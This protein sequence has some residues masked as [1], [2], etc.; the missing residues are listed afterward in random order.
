MTWSQSG[1]LPTDLGP[2]IRAAMAQA[3]RLVGEALKKQVQVGMRRGHS[4]HVY[5]TNFFTIGSGAGRRIVP[6]GSR[7]PHQ[8]SAAGEY[9]AI[10]KGTLLGSVNYQ[11][12]G[13]QYIRFYATAKHAGYQEYGTDKFS[14]RQNLKRAIDEADGIIRSIIEQIIWRALG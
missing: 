6:W 14:G 10:D 8:A 13:A 4:G 12:S 1:Q 7:S 3:G 2:K 9:S 5:T 11:V